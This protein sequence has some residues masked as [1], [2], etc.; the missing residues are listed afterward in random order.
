M[1]TRCQ[2]AVRLKE[3]SQHKGGRLA[4]FPKGHSAGRTPDKHREINLAS[5]IGKVSHTLGRTSAIGS[6]SDAARP[7]Q[8]GGIDGKS[9]D[10]ASLLVRAV[11][12]NYAGM[13]LDESSE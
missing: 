8:C 13:N 10:M 3:P 5:S 6:L 1:A 12:A 7:S 11:L 9:T 4:F 2:G